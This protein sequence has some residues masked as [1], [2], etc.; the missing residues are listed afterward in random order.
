[1]SDI[2][3]KILNKHSIELLEDAKKSSV[4]DLS[5][6]QEIDLSVVLEQINL[7]KDQVYLNKLEEAKK[8]W[9]LT[10]ELE[11]TKYQQQLAE[12]YQKET[13]QK[14]QQISELQAANQTLVNQIEQNKQQLSEKLANQIKI[15]KLEQQARIVELENKLANLELIQENQILQLTSKKDEQINNLKKDLELITREKLTKNIKLIGEE[16]ENYCLNEF[17]KISTF[18][19]QTSDLSKDNQAIKIDGESK[20]TKGDFIFKVYAEPEKQNLLLSVMCEM[21][22]EQLNS[23]NKKK[24]SDHYKKLDDDR[25]KKNLDYALLVSELEYETSDSLI[26]R[27]SDYK[28]MFVVRPMYFITMLGVLET[29][30]LKYK[31]LKLNRL[32]Q[33]LSFKEKQDILNE[34]EEFKNNLLDNALKNITNKVNEISK[35]AENIKKEATKI[36]EATELVINKHLNTVKNKIIGFKIEKK[37]VDKI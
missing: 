10:A 23:Q 13:E 19:F 7:K 36:L 24:N 9:N 29:I 26:Y 34:F 21:K 1:M 28:N 3:F 15:I 18:A 8:K 31:D 5:K 2:K 33:E 16:L 12:Q 35:S 6:A 32:Q 11:K 17:N 25:N 30:A 27:V 14:I 37:I 4:I 20:A 22:S